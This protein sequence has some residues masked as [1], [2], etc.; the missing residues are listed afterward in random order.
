[1]ARAFIYWNIHKGCFSVRYRGQVIAHATRF[2]AY[3]VEFKVH[4]G[5]RQRVLNT[6]RKN[7]HAGIVCNLTDLFC[8]SDGCERS[9]IR[10]TWPDATEARGSAVRENGMII[11][12]NPYDANHFQTWPGGYRVDGAHLVYG[13]RDLPY[14]KY[15]P[16]LWAERPV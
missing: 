14:P 5:A 8:D 16:M 6:G 13:K 4:K 2:L 3:G 9:D 12:Y 11:R 10:L 7:V 15:R 1:M